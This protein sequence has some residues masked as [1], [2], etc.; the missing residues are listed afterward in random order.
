M[1]QKLLNEKEQIIKNIKH[2]PLEDIYEEHQD[3]MQRLD[4]I[5]E[6]IRNIKHETHG[7]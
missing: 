7:C 4:E 6:Q 5:H 3:K 2:I 1:L